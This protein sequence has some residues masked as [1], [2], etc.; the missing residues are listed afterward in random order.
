MTDVTYGG[1]SPAY[2]RWHNQTG[3]CH[4]LRV[5]GGSIDAACGVQGGRRAVYLGGGYTTREQ[6]E[7]AT[8]THACQRC[9]VIEAKHSA[10]G[11]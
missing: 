9:L 5:R 6:C 8:G 11:V 1:W 3:T 7:H 4:Y 10:E 2:N